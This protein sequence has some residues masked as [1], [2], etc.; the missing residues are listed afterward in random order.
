MP[1]VLSIL[2][3]LS[4]AGCDPVDRASVLVAPHR[5][6]ADA[7]FPA[8]DRDP[9]VRGVFEQHTRSRDYRCHAAVKQV[10]R[11]V[12]RGPKDLHMTFEPRLNGA[13]YVARFTWVRSEDRTAEEFR[14]LVQAF[15]QALQDG[16]ASVEVLMGQVVD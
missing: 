7:L 5:A 15:G 12:C 4:L 8:A 11:Q 9:G 16:G 6:P 10:G 2:V 14:E 3:I 13:G 1:R